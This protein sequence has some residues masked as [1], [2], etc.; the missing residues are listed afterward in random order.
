MHEQ[1]E[2]DIKGQFQDI[3]DLSVPSK[4]RSL[5]ASSK[6]MMA[7]GNDGPEFSP[8]LPELGDDNGVYSGEDGSFNMENSFRI[9]FGKH[10]D[11]LSSEVS[12]DEE[13]LSMSM[14]LESSVNNNIEEELQGNEAIEYNDA[15]TSYVERLD[16]YY[17]VRYLCIYLQLND[18]LFFKKK[19]EGIHLI[20]KR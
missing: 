19:E 17:Q 12:A 8:V 9:M 1:V 20:T 4:L 2:M 7:E 14:G 15:H 3:H 10:G 13:L 11:H 16:L 6:I 18:F 5:A